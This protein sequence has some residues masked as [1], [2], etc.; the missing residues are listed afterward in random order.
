MKPKN[1]SRY[2]DDYELP[3]LRRVEKEDYEIEMD[4]EDY[5]ELSEKYGDLSKYIR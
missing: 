2:D 4:E 1:K 3:K 5:D